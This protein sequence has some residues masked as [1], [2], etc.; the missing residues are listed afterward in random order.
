MPE[1]GVHLCESQECLP[2]PTAILVTLPPHYA[3]PSTGL[4]CP[5]GEES[6]KPGL[7][8]LVPELLLKEAGG[9]PAARH[10]KRSE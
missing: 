7:L 1:P 9:F 8:S 2:N 10:M 6:K 4:P 5:D 3:L